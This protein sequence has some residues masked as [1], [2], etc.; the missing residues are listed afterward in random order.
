M[1]VQSK[2]FAPVT[3]RKLKWETNA[4]I[5]PA[6]HFFHGKYLLNYLLHQTL[7]IC[8]EN[9]FR[10]LLRPHEKKKNYKRVTANLPF[11]NGNEEKKSRCNNAL[12]EN[13]KWSVNKP[14]FCEQTGEIPPSQWK[15]LFSYVLESKYSYSGSRCLS[16]GL[17][18]VLVLPLWS[19]RFQFFNASSFKIPA[20]RSP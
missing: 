6:T 9:K 20:R 17:V 16:F 13:L 1:P 4:W 5:Q 15:L 7:F 11:K 10:V 18:F 8:W 14:S 12:S 3:K 19:V 2:F